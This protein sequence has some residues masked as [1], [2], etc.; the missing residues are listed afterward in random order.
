ME[1]Q[2]PVFIWREIILKNNHLKKLL[3]IKEKI[4]KICRWQIQ[5][6]KNSATIFVPTGE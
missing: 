2:L 4:V 6:Y 3:V 5:G 1:K